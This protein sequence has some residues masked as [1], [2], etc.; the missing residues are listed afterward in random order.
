MCIRD[1]YKIRQME[2]GQ[3]QWQISVPGEGYE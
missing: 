2:T 1:S 3:E